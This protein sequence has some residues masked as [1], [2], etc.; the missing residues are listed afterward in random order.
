MKSLNTFIK[1]KLVINK[2]YKDPT[3]GFDR[4]IDKLN[5]KSYTE[6]T[7]IKLIRFVMHWHE[8]NGTYSN[9]NN[10]KDSDN[11]FRFADLDTISVK[12]L[13]LNKDSCEISYKADGGGF[14]GAMNVANDYSFLYEYQKN[15][16]NTYQLCI[17][18]NPEFA[19]A[20]A[21]NKIIQLYDNNEET[22]YKDHFAKF[23][24]NSN[25]LKKMFGIDISKC[26]E[27][28]NS[29]YEGNYSF[30]LY[31]TSEYKNLK[32]YLSDIK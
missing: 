22:Q 27:S 7:D 16:G 1:E 15:S 3:I 8:D 19:G 26:K 20:D 23:K 14:D 24:I 2:E 32:N 17:I 6:N 12:D 28:I 5:R 13:S 18:I 9:V 30:T 25:D 11:W 31:K 10:T 29:N 21:V 4:I